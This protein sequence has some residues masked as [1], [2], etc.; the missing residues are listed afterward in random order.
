MAETEAKAAAPLAA[1]ADRIRANAVWIIG[2]FAAVGA[3]LAAGLQIGDVGELSTDD[4]PRLVAAFGGVAVAF[5]GIVLA[6][7]AASRVATRSHVSL[8]MLGTKGVLDKEKTTI[9]ADRALLLNYPSVEALVED[10]TAAYARESRLWSDYNEAKAQMPRSRDPEEK[11]KQK[12]EQLERDYRAAQKESNE[13]GRVS[14]KVLEVASFLRVQN[15]FEGALKFMFA[16]AVLAAI[17]IV[18]FGWGINPPADESLD[19]GEVLPRTPSDVVV[20]LNASG[21]AEFG[22]RLGPECDLTHVPAVA[23]AVNGST[24]RVV[25]VET[26]TCNSIPMRVGTGNGQVIPPPKEEE[27]TPPAERDTHTAAQIEPS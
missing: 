2:A 17:G 13:A 7:A 12:V 1:A 14:G 11:A 23:T 4:W 9:N 25:T 19:G 22:E 16:G 26:E 5:A 6:I 3:I 27:P 15:T 24:Y 18:A 8:N 10:A 21:Q 20:I